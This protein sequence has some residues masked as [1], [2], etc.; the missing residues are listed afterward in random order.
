MY[1][2]DPIVPS[3]REQVET[4]IAVNPT[5]SLNLIGA[6]ITFENQQKYIG[7]YYS[8][9]GGINWYGQ[10]DISGPGAAD[11]MVAFDPD[12]T[13]YLLYQVRGEGKLY[14]HK[15]TDGGVTWSSR[16]TVANM[17]QDRLDKPWMGIDPLRNANGYFNI[18]ISVTELGESKSKQPQPSRIQLYKSVNGGSNFSLVH[19]ENEG[20]YYLQ[21][22]SVAVGPIYI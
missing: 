11:P 8:T 7:V 4:S 3:S 5:D 20:T 12:G 22:S 21:G 2:Q 10:D 15:S 13:A 9:N 19:T 1:A 14:L 18:Y 16:I 6:A 17:G